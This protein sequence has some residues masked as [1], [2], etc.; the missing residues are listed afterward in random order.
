MSSLI[1]TST[2]LAMKHVSSLTLCEQPA[3]HFLSGVNE[4]RMG[5]DDFLYIHLLFTIYHS[6]L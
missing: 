4:Q 2:P 1:Y 5:D 6:V 3:I